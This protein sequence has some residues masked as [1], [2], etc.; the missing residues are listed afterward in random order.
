MSQPRNMLISSFT[1]Q[2][3]TLSFPLLLFYLQLGLVVTKKDR[4]VECI[5]KK[6]INSLVQAAV[7][8]RT[9]SNENPNS[10][11]VAET[12]KLVANSSSGYQIMDCSRHTVKKYLSDQKTHAAVNRKQFKKI[13]HVNNS[14]Y[15]IEIAK[16][17][18]E[19]K[20]PV[21]V[22]SSF[23]NTENCECWSFI[24]VSS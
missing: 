11:V 15:E 12:M 5:P 16:A 6:K 17:H 19:H 13:H 3:G 1:L 9:K 7:D 24:T 10:S 14:I 20:K 18:I 2:N 22:S 23:F 21:I 8:A 4:F